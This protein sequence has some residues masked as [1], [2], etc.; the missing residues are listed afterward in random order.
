LTLASALYDIRDLAHAYGGRPVLTINRLLIQEASI[1][2]LMGPNGSGKS[3][4]LRLLGFVEKPHEGRILFKGHPAEPFSVDVRF[5]VT[6]LP[7]DPYIMKR[8]VFKNIAYG[9]E[10][11]GDSS[12]VSSRV[13][14]ALSMV[15]LSAE[16]FAHRPWSALSGGEAQRV[17]LAARLA[18]Q[19]KVLL[20][21][22]PTSSVDTASS[23]LI[24]DASLRARDRWGTTLII[25]SHDRQ[26][27]HEVCDDMIHLF[28]GRIFG[29]GLENIVFGPWKPRPDRF[30]EKRLADGQSVLVPAPPGADAA[31]IL[32]IV[33]VHDTPPTQTDHP[34]GSALSGVVSRLTLD[35]HSGDILAT[36]I[37]ATLPFTIRLHLE[38]AK[39]Y[40]LLPGMRVYAAYRPDSVRW[41]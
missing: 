11:R 13:H 17:A 4:L 25:A 22:E 2:G 37:V 28:D 26:W 10:L 24:K 31:A 15:G 9:L 3:T 18:L 30:W 19:P 14:E 20:L 6:L 12:E 34:G 16:T 38:Q 33:S 27:L 41:I 36:V 35:P 1:V 7:Q 39:K 23:Q 5:Q 21:D 40:N 29:N 8:S 32:D